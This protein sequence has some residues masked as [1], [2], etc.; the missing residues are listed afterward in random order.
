MIVRGE[1][2]EIFAVLVRSVDGGS[3]LQARDNIKVLAFRDADR[4]VATAAAP[5][6]KD[7]HTIDPDWSLLEWTDDSAAVRI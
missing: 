5:M 2:E 3:Y 4:I 6:V 1:G 7:L